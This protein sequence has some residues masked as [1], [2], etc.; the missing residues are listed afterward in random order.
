MGLTS[1]HHWWKRWSQAGTSGRRRARPSSP[2]RSCPQLTALEDRTLLSVSIYEFGANISPKSTPYTI[3][4][5]PDGNLWFTET[6]ADR[7]GR[8]TPTGVVTEFAKGISAGS[9]LLAITAGPDGNLWFTES[10]A[11]RIGRITPTGVVTEFDKGISAGSQPLDITAGPDGNL[12]FTEYGLN[13]IARITPAGVVT[14]FNKNMPLTSGPAGITTGPDGNLWFT[15]PAGRIGRMT[16][17]GGVTEFDKGISLN[18][19]PAFITTGADGN[20][21]FTEY[22][23]GRIGRITPTGVVTEFDKGIS[24]DATPYGITPGP[25][26]NLWFAEGKTDRIGRI[27]PAGVITEF[28]K[29]ISANGFPSGITTGPDGNLWFTEPGGNR[30]G[31]AVIQQPPFFAVGGAPG[32]ALVYKADN[33]LVADFQPF[34]AAYTGGISVAVADVNG[35]GFP[36][37]IVGATSGNPDVRVYDGKDLAKG[38]FSPD[39]KS[40]LAQFFA[41]GLDFNVG[42]NVAAG[43]IEHNGFADIVTGATAGNPNVHV[44]RGVDIARKQFDPNGKSLL[45]SFFP[46]ALQFNVGA[47]VAVGDVNGDGYADIV[48]GATVGNPDV[49]VYNGQDLAKGTFSPDG[50]SMLAQ[51]FAYGLNFNIGANVAVGDVNGDGFG[52]VIT[53]ASAGNPDVRVYSGKDI[54]KGDFQ[55]QGASQ[56]D[57]FFAYQLNFNVGVTVAAADLDGDG[58]AEILTGASAGSPHY[59]LLKGMP[60]GIEPAA[61]FQG[62]PN[63]LHGG[64]TVGA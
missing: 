29:G 5:G 54:A 59:R 3:A 4:A 16:L 2:L 58:Q 33:T 38:T 31:R 8:I 37:L 20:L 15:E 44:Y 30:I 42:A 24:K 64:I 53:G 57:Q 35:D 27:T 19:A 51:W 28:D 46:Y 1:W 7:I 23:S 13:R 61:L 14:E 50:K 18:S 10:K 48:T 34:G 41:Y 26:G 55:P 43:D 40:L 11:G 25:D 22:F 12:W 21:W 36:D 39:G 45:T 60:T 63:D 62:L 9:E 47:N 56:L 6:D 17:A 32:H 52:D 49:R